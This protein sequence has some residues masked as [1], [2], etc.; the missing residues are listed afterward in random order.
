MPEPNMP[1][2]D[3]S[4]NFP[5]SPT[6]APMDDSFLKLMIEVEQDLTKFEMETLR[7]KRLHVDLKTKAK[8]WLP[9]ADGV[10]PVCNELGISEIL[11]MMRSRATVIG[12]LTKKTDEQIA[13]D[14][15][16]FHR[17]LIELFQLRADDWDLDEE[18]AK[19]LLEACIGIIEDIML[20][21]L[22]GFTAINIKSQ[23]TRHE[24]ATADN[25]SNKRNILGL[26]R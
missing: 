2:P 26:R 18:M 10:N 20:S 3:P 11:G 21:S 25:D 22:G 14:M 24:N 17:A 9:I 4:M 6:G 13:M 8:Q 15:F 19:P 23:Y 12:R 1:T 5:V 7:R 16:Q